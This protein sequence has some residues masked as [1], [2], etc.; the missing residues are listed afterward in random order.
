MQ[1]YNIMI[2]IIIV[3]DLKQLK[4]DNDVLD[5]GKVRTVRS[6]KLV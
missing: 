4:V 2:Y 3:I 1:Y 6:L 5:D